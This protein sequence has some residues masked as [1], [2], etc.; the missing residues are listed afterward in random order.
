MKRVNYIISLAACLA[1]L[2]T[3]CINEEPYSLESVSLAVNVTRADTQ[4]EQQ[5]DQIKNVMIWA[6]EKPGGNAVSNTAAGWRSYTPSAQTFTSVTVH[7][8]LPMCNGEAN[9]RLVAI[10]N[11]GEFGSI[12]D[13]EGN[14]L[15]LDANTTYQQLTNARFKSDVVNTSLSEGTPGEPAA[16]PVSHWTDVKV[17]EENTHSSSN[18][19]TVDMPVYRTVGKTQL[20]VARNNTFDLNLTSVKLIN[21][22]ATDEGVALASAAAGWARDASN[23]IDIPSWFT[24]TAAA[25]L[26]Q[27]SYNE[28][29]IST[30]ATIPATNTNFVY[31]DNKIP[32]ATTGHLVAHYVCGKILYETTDACSYSDPT[33]KEVPTGNGYY[34][35]IK[36]KIGNGDVIRRYV[37]LYPI[38]RNH[39]YQVRALIKEDG[40]IVVNYTVADW[41]D[42]IWDLEFA[43][44]R[45][46][47][48]LPAPDINSTPSTYPR[49]KYTGNEDG[50]AVFYFQMM[51][52]QGITWKPTIFASEGDFEVRVYEVVG[53]DS[54]TGEPILA[55]E[56]TTGDILAENGQFYAVKVVALNPAITENYNSVRLG[57]THAPQW[58]EE[59]SNLLLIN[60]LQSDGKYLWYKKRVDENGNITDEATREQGD[61]LYVE[62]YPEK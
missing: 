7:I 40:G 23:N 49:I 19:L 30:T 13:D 32:S 33:Y 31:A 6:F 39:D 62:I 48:L 50:A 61:A 20:F 56:Q 57:I 52:P 43:A 15:T 24:D 22:A 4:S 59:K 54:A 2:L 1:A 37:P 46:T 29:L 3:S 35:E 36:Y 42:V 8:P 17:T 21:T 55:V 28:D 51:G 45:N 44:A 41:T 12:V 25:P 9:Y 34:Y 10:V 11:K 60:T 26:E 38:V 18:H 16:M 47:N 14:A 58:N 53:T 27:K 5:G